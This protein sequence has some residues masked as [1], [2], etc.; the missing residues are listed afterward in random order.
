MEQFLSSGFFRFFLFPVLSTVLGVAIKYVSRNDQYAKF[1]KEDLAVGLELIMTAC[2]TF[3]VLTSDKAF[4][5]VQVNEQLATVL[6]T[7]ATDSLATR[8]NQ[9]A[10]IELQAE[11][12]EMSDEQ[13]GSGWL[14]LGL[15]VGMWSV[16]TLV[17]KAG[18]ESETEMKPFIGIGLP[19]AFGLAALVTVMMVTSQ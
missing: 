11:A 19:L 16:S 13:S 7:V 17:R 18:W 2:L 10:A 9:A 5:L 12:I 3:V 15:F 14:L 8:E 6:E 1:R 4:E